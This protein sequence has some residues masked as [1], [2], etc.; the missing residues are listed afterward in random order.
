[1]ELAA[2]LS[3]SAFLWYVAVTSKEKM[4]M[5]WLIMV[6]LI[7]LSPIIALLFPMFR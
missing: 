6:G 1:M 5:A 3:L 2:V 7:L 4:E